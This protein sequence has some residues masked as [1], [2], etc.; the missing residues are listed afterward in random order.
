[1]EKISRNYHVKLQEMCDCYMN[2][3]F[4]A[5]MEHPFNTQSEALE[6]ES[7]KYFSLLILYALTVKAQKLKVKKQ[8]GTLKITVTSSDEKTTISPPPEEIVDK[9]FEIIRAITHIDS[10]KGE[11]ALAL[12]VR[13][14]Q[15]DLQIK[16]KKK[17]D[18]ES[19][20]I[21]FPNLEDGI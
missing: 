13:G 16:V 17:D 7:I 8:K 12:G 9:I 1:M 10:D 21:V 5:E 4:M 15:V 18:E 20:K 19:L 3:D 2:T 14:S 11:S 6:E